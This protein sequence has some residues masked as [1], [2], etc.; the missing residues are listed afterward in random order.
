MF[1]WLANVLVLT[2]FFGMGN[3]SRPAVVVYMAGEALWTAV[4]YARGD[5]ALAALCV[6]FFLLAIRMFVLWSR[7]S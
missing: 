2:G 6:V 5:W 4:A 7:I 3:K 1:G